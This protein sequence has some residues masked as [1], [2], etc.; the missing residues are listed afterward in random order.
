[1]VSVHKLSRTYVGN[2]LSEIKREKEVSTYS[3]GWGKQ[4]FLVL[5]VTHTHTHTHTCTEVI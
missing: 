4:T 2:L 1:M 3:L 5:F